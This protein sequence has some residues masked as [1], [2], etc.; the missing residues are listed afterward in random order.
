[1]SMSVYSFTDCTLILRHPSLGVLNVIGQGIGT[2]TI[3]MR[4]DRTTMDT[5][6]DG[7]VMVSKIKDRSATATIQLQQDSESNQ[8]LLKWYN[9]LEK[10]PTIEWAQMTAT[11]NSPTTHEQIIMKDVAFQKLP[12]RNYAAQGQQNSYS[13]MIADCQ[14]N[15][16]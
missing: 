14:Q 9:Y 12:D 1:M 8:T 4:N 13:L 16:I 5:G 2:I 15:V 3:N 6:A 7:R 11:M 10:A